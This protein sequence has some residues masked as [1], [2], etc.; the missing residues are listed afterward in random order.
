MF[1]L[2]H[3]DFLKAP[4]ALQKKIHFQMIK[5]ILDDCARMSHFLWTILLQI[6][7]VRL[8]HQ[9]PRAYLKNT[10]I[11]KLSAHL[12]FFIF[13][14]SV[15]FL[16]LRSFSTPMLFLTSIKEPSSEGSRL[17]GGGAVISNHLISREPSAEFMGVI[18]KVERM[19]QHCFQFEHW[20]EGKKLCCSQ[21]TGFQE[22]SMHSGKPGDCFLQLGI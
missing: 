1:L 20:K 17:W 22:I 2:G 15:G 18:L 11:Q 14:Y 8:N 19:P 13:L 3:H 10:L 7:N 4:L 21:V 16:E 5:Y 9:H 6:R 12:H